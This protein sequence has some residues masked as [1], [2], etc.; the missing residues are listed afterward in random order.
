MTLDEF[1]NLVAV[2][3]Q[4]RT[5]YH[6][7]DVRNLPSIREHGLLSMLELKERGLHATVP[8]GNQW[9]LDRD[10]VCGMDQYVHL[11]FFAS[12]PMEFKAREEKRLE[13]T[14]FLRVRPAVLHLPGVM[15]TSD[16][17][18]QAGVEPQPVGQLLDQLDLQVIYTRTDWKE[19]SI[20]E[21]LRIAKRYEILIPRQVPLEFIENT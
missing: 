6:F 17:S 10:A 13:Q 19:A 21:R 14:R 16:V 11:C 1:V 3:R 8:G 15:V 5:F 7:T 2:N 4:N 20:K 18:N 9:S 12:H